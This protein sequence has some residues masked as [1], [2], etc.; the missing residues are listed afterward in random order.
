MKGRRPAGGDAD[1]WPPD[2][3]SRRRACKRHATETRKDL[4]RLL[5]HPSGRQSGNQEKVTFTFRGSTTLAEPPAFLPGMDQE[6]WWR[7]RPPRPS[8]SPGPRWSLPGGL[9]GTNAAPARR[10]PR[11]RAVTAL[12]GCVWLTLRSLASFSRGRRE[13]SGLCRVSFTDQSRPKSQLAGSCCKE[14]E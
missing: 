12:L 14:K 4:C 13:A 8:P 10:S 7:G 2:R 5:P 11:P 9:F 1:L 3:L 6:G